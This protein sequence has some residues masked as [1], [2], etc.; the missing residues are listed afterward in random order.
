MLAASAATFHPASAEAQAR[1]LPIVGFLHTGSSSASAFLYASF[2]GG[3]AGAGFVE[4]RNVVIEQ[5][6]ANGDYTKLPALAGGLVRRQVA[7][8]AAGGPPAAR[9]AKA[10]TSNIPIVFSSGEDPVKAG[11]VASLARPGGNMTG[12]SFLVDDLAAKRL[13]LARE[14]VPSV[15]LFALLI[16]RTT[17]GVTQ[18]QQTQDAAR[19][20]SKRLLVLE[21]GTPAEIEAAYESAARQK[22]GALLIGGDPFLFIQRA[23]IIALAAKF[24]MPTIAAAREFPDA[25]GLMSYGANIAD[26]YR[27]VGVYAARILKGEKPADLPVQQ[28]IKFELVINAKTAKALGLAIPPT[29]LIRG[30]E[31]IE[32]IGGTKVLRP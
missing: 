15:D 7:V 18:S 2:R 10:A 29:I 30:D 3:L 11:F 21:A 24:A 26:V 28:P 13:D 25:G 14:L 31:V 16:N 32:S 5:R 27:Q 22:A 17:V 23:Q 6:W 12:I 20:M 8:I 9:A 19:L 1:S 4:G